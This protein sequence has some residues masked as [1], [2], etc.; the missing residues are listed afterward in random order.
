MVSENMVLTKMFG[1]KAEEVRG[2]LRILHNE[3]V[4]NLYFAL[5]NIMV[6]KSRTVKWMVHRAHMGEMR[7]AYKILIVIPEW[8]RPLGNLYIAGRIILTLC[9]T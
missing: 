6:V 7:K 8:M 5:N 2:G 3:K 4:Y 9:S 1:P